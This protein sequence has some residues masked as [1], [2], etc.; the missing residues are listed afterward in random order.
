MTRN[1]YKKFIL[2][3]SLLLTW[4]QAHHQGISDPPI[5][6]GCINTTSCAF[7]ITAKSICPFGKCNCYQNC[8]CWLEI[9]LCGSQL[10]QY[11]THGIQEQL[12]LLQ[13]LGSLL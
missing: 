1:S 12:K 11:N 7:Y 3:V 13:G 10:W 5:F 2:R 9:V 8:N 6:K 4:E